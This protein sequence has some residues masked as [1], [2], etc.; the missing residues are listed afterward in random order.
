LQ[1]RMNKLL[2]TLS[3]EGEMTMLVGDDS[4]SVVS[5][6]PLTLLEPIRSSGGGGD[7]SSRADS[8]LAAMPSSDCGSGPTRVRR[9]SEVGEETMRSGP[10]LG[11]SPDSSTTSPFVVTVDA[12]ARR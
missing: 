11:S 4:D 2:H 5:A 9:E 6:R 3:S 10:Q 8:G 1:K 7:S 12:L